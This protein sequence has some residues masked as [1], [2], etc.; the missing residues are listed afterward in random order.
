MKPSLPAAIL[1]AT[2]LALALPAHAGQTIS[3]L[4]NDTPAFSDGDSLALLDFTSQ[5]VGPAPFDALDGSD[6]FENFNVSYTHSYTPI[7][8]T[9]IITSATLQI[10]LYEHEGGSVGAATDGSGDVVTLADEQLDFYSVE[11]TSVK[12]ELIAAGFEDGGQ[13]LNNEYNEYTITLP[14]SL[15]PDLADG[16]AFV[17]LALKGPVFSPAV[18][19]FLDD[20]VNDFNGAGIL[21]SKLTINTV[22]IPEPTTATLL[23]TLTALTLTPRRRLN[24]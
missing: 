24:R 21:F 4:G 22:P 8:I 17:E 2:T 10:G 16:S 13:G 14:M 9:E 6:L 23:L 12:S 15:Y 1:I 20:I 19:V 5:L 7:P 18:L 11:G 3:L